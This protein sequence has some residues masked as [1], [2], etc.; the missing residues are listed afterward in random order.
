LIINSSGPRER[1]ICPFDFGDFEDRLAAFAEPRTTFL[2][3]RLLEATLR[4]DLET[5]RA[6]RALRAADFFE[7][8]FFFFGLAIT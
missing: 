3:V 4:G 7:E 2:E 6:D 8:L 5:L 1:S